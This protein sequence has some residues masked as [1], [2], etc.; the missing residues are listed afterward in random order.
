MKTRKTLDR[1][2]SGVK[3]REH[4]LLHASWV[5]LLEVH[6]GR[7]SRCGVFP[8]GGIEKPRESESS[9]TSVANAHSGVRRGRTGPYAASEPAG[10]AEQCADHTQMRDDGQP[11]TRVRVDEFGHDRDG[12]LLDLSQVLAASRPHVEIPVIEAP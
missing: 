8:A 6:A 4:P 12:A 10:F 3:A 1:P 11:L 2:S 5:R 9:P 7:S